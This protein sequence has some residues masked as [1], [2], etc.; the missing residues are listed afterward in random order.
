MERD[1]PGCDHARNHL[2]HIDNDDFDAIYSLRRF[3][4][5]KVTKLDCSRGPTFAGEE[6]GEI[7]S[8]SH[9]GGDD[10]DP[11]GRGGGGDREPVHMTNPISRGL[12]D[13]DRDRTRGHLMP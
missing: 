8:A 9:L 4:S 12:V 2:W 11:T 3:L 7:T 13:S 6:T 10:P 1:W 5:Q